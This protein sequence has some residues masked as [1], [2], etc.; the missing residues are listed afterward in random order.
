MEKRID[1]IFKDSIEHFEELPK[2]TRWSPRTGWKDYK[3]QFGEKPGKI[4]RILYFTVSTAALFALIV[5]TFLFYPGIKHQQIIVANDDMRIK[6]VTL[7]DGNTLWLNKNSSVE[8]PSK[9]DSKHNRLIINGEAYLEI[10]HVVCREYFIQAHN[11]VVIAETPV[12]FNIAAW[13]DDENVDITVSVG[14]VKIVEESY[15]EGMAL[16]VAQGN[17]CSVHKSR[18]LV[19]ASVNKDNNFLAWKTC[20][21]V[22]ENQPIAKVTDILAKYYHTRIEIEDWDVAFC[23]FSGS[24]EEQPLDSILDQIKSDLN[25]EIKQTDSKITFSGKGC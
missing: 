10:K 15:T 17:Y 13:H 1:K 7:P 9:I 18:K 24:F 20:K 25:L 3:R 8:Y 16:I 12:S 11:A 2:D 21:L 14:A 6:E 19:Y 4:K 5:T 23:L 22:F